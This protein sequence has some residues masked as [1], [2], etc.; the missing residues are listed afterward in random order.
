M[1][2]QEGDESG[3]ARPL[4]GADPALS[5]GLAMADGDELVARLQRFETRYFPRFQERFQ[6]LV[7][8]RHADANAK[9]DQIQNNIIDHIAYI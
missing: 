7:A 9:Y 6:N 8:P 4:P 2:G 3:G 5:P 1:A